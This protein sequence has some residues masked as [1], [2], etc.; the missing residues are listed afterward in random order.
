MTKL[1]CIVCP[2]GCH[3]EVDETTYAVTGEACE[4]GKAYGQDELR[5]PLRMI[6][7]T[8]KIIGAHHRRCPVKTAMPIP[9]PL[10]FDAIRLLDGVELAAPIKIGHIVI[11]DICG[12]GIP[13]ITTRSLPAV[14]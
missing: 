6:T 12:T 5:N 11:P 9:K 8:V 10:I 3:L 14:K 4:R 7:S 2:K 1:I 13:F